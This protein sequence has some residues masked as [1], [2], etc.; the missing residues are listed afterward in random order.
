MLDEQ[1][2]AVALAIV[3]CGDGI[4]RLRTCATSDCGRVLVDLLG[5]HSRRYCD[6]KCGNRQQVAAYRQRHAANDTP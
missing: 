3:V 2:T 1:H 5:D 4:D 6:T